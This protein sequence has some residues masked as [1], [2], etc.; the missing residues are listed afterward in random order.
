MH[1]DDLTLVTAAQLLEDDNLYVGRPGDPDPDRRTTLAHLAGR[2]LG[3]MPEAVDDLEAWRNGLV[4][5]GE[6]T[7]EVGATT[8][9]PSITYSNRAGRYFKFGPLVLL[10]LRVETTA[11]SGGS[12]SIIIQGIPFAPASSMGANGYGL[13]AADLNGF[14]LGSTVRGVTMRLLSTHIGLV[15]T[16]DAIGASFITI[17][18]W[19]SGTGGI[20]HGSLIYATD[21]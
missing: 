19:P 7:P 10:T 18:N 15:M 16:R 11:R 13:G 21:E 8:T 2:I 3:S 9:N 5:S 6:W 17:T 14:D 12:G 20:S 4:Q 1:V